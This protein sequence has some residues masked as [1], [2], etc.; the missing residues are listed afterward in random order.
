MI[1]LFANIMIQWREVESILVITEIVLILILYANSDIAF[2]SGFTIK[3]NF[4][5][6]KKKKYE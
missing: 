1:I 2:N 4:F 3:K 5:T 6:K